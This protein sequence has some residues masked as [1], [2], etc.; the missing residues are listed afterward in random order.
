M[1]AHAGL[2]EAYHGRSSGRV[3]AFALYGDTTGETDEFGLPVRLDWAR[4]YRGHAA[5]VYGH[6]PV[7]EAEWLNGTANIDTGCVFGGKLT[8]L[9]YPEMD[10]VSVSALRTYYEPIRPLTGPPAA[11]GETHARQL[12]IADVLGKQVIAPGDGVAHRALA[13]GSIVRSVAE[14]RQCRAEP[15]QQL[16][17]VRDQL[18]RRIRVQLV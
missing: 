6:T 3:R 5:V 18:H 2:K 12:D 13:V 16:G 15:G 8:A 9:R 10:L 4:D 1:V 17:V 11:M 14:Q 7:P